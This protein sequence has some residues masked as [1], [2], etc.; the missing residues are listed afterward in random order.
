MA[1]DGVDYYVLP[2]VGTVPAGGVLA[3]SDTAYSVLDVRRP[4]LACGT[5][6]H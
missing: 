2:S 6:A 5:M 3:Y 1:S 4:A